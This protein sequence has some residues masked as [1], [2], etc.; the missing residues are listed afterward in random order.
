MGRTDARIA[1]IDAAEAI[2]AEHGLAAMSLREVGV[3]AGQLN[4]TAPQ[5]HFGDRAGLVTAVVETRMASIDAARGQLLAELDATPPVSVR[6]LVAAL[7]C[8]LAEAVARRPGS[9]YARF[10]VQATFD[11]VL[12][13]MIDEHVRA[14]SARDVI[15]RLTGCTGLAA[16]LEASRLQGLLTTAV[17]T[18]ARWEASPELFAD[19]ALLPDLV[20]TATAALMARSC[21]DESSDQ[22]NQRILGSTALTPKE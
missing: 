5:Y 7:I 4:K 15:T 22:P 11:P 12:S 1:M 18:L 3:R 2:V 20:D 6:Q 21:Q 17:T 14:G 9:R 13:S 19:P 8:P 10:L 16:N